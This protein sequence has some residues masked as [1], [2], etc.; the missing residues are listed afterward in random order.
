MTQLVCSPLLPDSWFPEDES[1]MKGMKAMIV[2]A[3]FIGWAVG[4]QFAGNWG[5]RLGRRPT[6]FRV[7]TDSCPCRS[8][9][10]SSLLS[11]GDHPAYWRVALMRYARVLELFVRS[12]TVTC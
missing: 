10:L 1:A 4:C 6:F 7:V 9:A 8:V 3:Y 12:V 2:P 5:D 11:V